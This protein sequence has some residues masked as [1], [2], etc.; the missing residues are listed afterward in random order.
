MKLL[1]NAASKKA[2]LEGRMLCIDPSS[3]GSSKR[4]DKSVAG[5][6]EFNAGILVGYGTIEYPDEKEVFKRLK[7]V[8]KALEDK[9]GND[10]FDI[11]V[12][13]DIR[14]YR[15]QQSLIQSCGVYIVSLSC[16]EFFQPNVQ[17]WKSVARLWGGYVKSDEQDAIYIG[18]ATVAI[19]LGY[20]SSL[21]PDQKERIIAKAKEHI[22]YEYYGLFS[23]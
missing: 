4:G 9:F 3:G 2:V 15:A 11:F 21:K 6:A 13:E 5:W 14:G 8:K 17:T 20:V 23:V 1:Q 18:Y 16:S 22:G 19:A 12:L 10:H 7:N